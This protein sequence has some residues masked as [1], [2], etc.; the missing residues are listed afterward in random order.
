MTEEVI[1]VDQDDNPIGT[2]EKLEAHQKGVLHR[3]FSVFIFNTKNELLL[4]QRALDKYH[5][6]GLWSNT[7]C[8]H[9][10]PDEAPLQAAKR[11][12]NEEMGINSELTFISKFLYKTRFNNGLFEHELDYIYIGTS[13][14]LPIINTEEVK[15]FRYAPLQQIKADLQSNP[16]HY[17]A[18]FK[19]C[20]SEIEQIFK[21]TKS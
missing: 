4:Q 21:K 15:D 3:A 16:A 8:S 11:R 2:M 18:W 14:T 12:L 5:S 20:F 13:D 6:A 7:C 9:P 1:L 17:T 19:L 10:R